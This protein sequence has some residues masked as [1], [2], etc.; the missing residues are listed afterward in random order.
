MPAPPH[1]IDGPL[2]ELIGGVVGLLDLD[3]FLPGL[4][5]ALRSAVPCDW[6]SLN[7]LAPDPAQTAVLIEPEFPPEAHALYALHAFENPL[8]ERYQRTSDGRAYRFS[9]VVTPE[10]LHAT[11]LFREFYAPLGLEYQIAFT[12]PHP[13]RRL[14]AVALSRASDDFSDA[15]RDLLDAARPFLIQ[16]YRNAVEHTGL[17]K[18]IEMRQRNPR[19]PLDDPA[20]VDALG[21]R[22]VTTREAEVLA[23]LATGRSNRA[24]AEL[25][26]VSERT[27]QKH[28][29]R[30]FRKLK[31]QT[32]RD[33]VAFAW[34][35][36]GTPGL[37]PPR[38]D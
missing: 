22:G 1:A 23:W 38:V 17:L 32:R 20:L 37:H 33:A 31:V 9:D 12:L 14:L 2:I 4:L 34:S 26:G 21:A 15:A 10:Q 5:Q 35:L 7:D 11:A 36:I 8:V 19:L 28:V 13:P 6:I 24:V 27:V 16:A 25:L 3:E 18:E 30:C 29:E